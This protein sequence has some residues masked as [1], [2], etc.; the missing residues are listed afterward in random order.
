MLKNS[1]YLNSVD[2]EWV[3]KHGKFVDINNRL[4][5]Y[6]S[7]V[8]LE[9]ADINYF[10][11]LLTDNLLYNSSFDL[12]FYT[13]ESTIMGKTGTISQVGLMDKVG[14]TCKYAKENN[15]PFTYPMY[16]ITR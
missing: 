10:D 13:H 14:N 6:H 1:Y 5:F 3:T 2:S 11:S 7:H 16:E 12:E 9:S 15:I 8:R 4:I